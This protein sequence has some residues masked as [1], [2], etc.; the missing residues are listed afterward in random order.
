M[1]SKNVTTSQED[2]LE[3]ILE[4][5]KKDC[6]VRSKDIADNLG[7]HRSTVTASL[8]S[9]SKKKLINYKPYEPI[10]LTSAGEKLA[11]KVTNRHKVLCRFFIDILGIE[12]KNADELACKI[13]HS[14]TEE[15]I[16]KLINKNF[17]RIEV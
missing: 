12:N 16:K 6:N 10:T 17:P 15:I 11:I 5:S 13:E 2:Y 3:T 7:V 8:K 1:L 14:A 9:L 4:L